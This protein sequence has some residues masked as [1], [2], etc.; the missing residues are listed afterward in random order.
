M[1]RWRDAQ[2]AASAGKGNSVTSLRLHRER[3]VHAR[4]APQ[5]FPCGTSFGALSENE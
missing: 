1:K 3:F 5:C 2:G 4:D